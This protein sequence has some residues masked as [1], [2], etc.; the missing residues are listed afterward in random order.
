[1]AATW[2]TLDH[3]LGVDGNWRNCLSNKLDG[4]EDHLVSRRALDFWRDID[5]SAQRTTAIAEVDALIAAS[6]I[7]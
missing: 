6:E 4:T 2:R 5:M 1:M 7:D 3:E